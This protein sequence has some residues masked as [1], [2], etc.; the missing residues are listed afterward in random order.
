MQ[1]LILGADGYIGR[2][3]SWYLEDRGMDVVGIDSLIKRRIRATVPLYALPVETTI[4]DLRDLRPRDLEGF[5]AVVDLAEIPSAPYSMSDPEAGERTIQNNL[6][7]TY[8]LVQALRKIDIPLVKLGTMGEYG[9]PNIDIEEG[10]IDIQHNGRS[11]R[12]LYPKTPGSLYHLSKVFDSDLLAFACRTWGLRVTDLNQGFVYGFDPRT[13][14]WYDAIWGTALNRFVAQAVA[15]HPLTVYGKGGQTRG[16]INI[17]DTLA[18]IEIALLNPPRPGEF[19]VF[20]QFTEQRSV[21]SLAEQVQRVADA[22]GHPAEIAHI[23]NPRTEKEEH[24]Y[25]ARNTHLL[26]LGLTPRLLTDEVIA[27]MIEGVSR[28]AGAIRQDQILPKVRWA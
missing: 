28:H 20:N 24:Y 1:V 10:W 26:D 15:G 2:M 22:L 4:K 11:D 19:R 16:I 6:F 8:A 25:N 12:L 18:C 27:G 9:T 17:L 13:W 5:S 7:G 23:D 3:L 21:L 14:Y